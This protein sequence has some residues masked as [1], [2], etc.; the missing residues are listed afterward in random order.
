MYS[1][2][3]GFKRLLTRLSNGAEMFGFINV[4]SRRLMRWT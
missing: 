4:T 3:A 1:N 2:L